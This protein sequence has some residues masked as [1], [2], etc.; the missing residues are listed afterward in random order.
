VISLLL[1]SFAAWCL[2]AALTFFI[3]WPA[4]WVDPLG[5]VQGVLDTAFGY[6]ATPHATANFFLGKSVTD[7]GS[8]FYP[9]ALAFRMTP[10]TVLGLAIA[11]PLLFTGRKVQS[12]VLSLPKGRELSGPTCVCRPFHYTYDYRSEEVR[13]LHAACDSCPGHRGRLGISE[14]WEADEPAL[15]TRNL[16]PGTQNPYHPVP[17]SGWTH[18][19]LS[20]P[21]SGILQ[22]PRGGLIQSCPGAACG[23]G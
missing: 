18:R 5:T 7:P 9:V 23:L 19:V 11:L 14:A 12:G 2:A 22:P 17:A 16:E 15:R 13:P 4:V 3:F 20:P 10:L 21:L 1:V 6:A 8:W